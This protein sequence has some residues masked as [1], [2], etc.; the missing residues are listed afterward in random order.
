MGEDN[1]MAGGAGRQSS[2]RER[3]RALYEEAIYR[4]FTPEGELILRVGA[5]SEPLDRLLAA[6]AARS[7][8]FLT[9]AN[10]GS[11]LLPEQM[12][13]E[14]N[15]RL[16]ARL[17]EAGWRSF[18]GVSGSPQGDWAEE[19]FLVLRIPETEA[20]ALAREFEQAAILIGLPRAPVRL[21]FVED[22]GARAAQAPGR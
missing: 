3:L 5:R 20:V 22:R 7:S 21:V 8:A 19:S 16:V 10:P 2:D 9:A 1:D 14:R 13:R 17:A 4:V 12:N 18:P 15:A 11:R 6:R